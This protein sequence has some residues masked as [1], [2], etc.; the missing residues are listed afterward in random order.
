MGYVEKPGMKPGTAPGTRGYG[1]LVRRSSSMESCAGVMMAPLSCG[2]NASVLTR[3]VLH[4][5]PQPMDED[6]SFEPT[7]INT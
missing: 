2:Q 3:P 5:N 1:L 4:T 7:K 6:T